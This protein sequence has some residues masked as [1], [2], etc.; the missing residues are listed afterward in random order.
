MIFEDIKHFKYQLSEQLIIKIYNRTI[1][2]GIICAG[3]KIKVGLQC[4]SLRLY[5]FSL[6]ASSEGELILRLP[7]STIKSNVAF[8]NYRETMSDKI[9]RL[10]DAERQYYQQGNRL[11][12]KSKGAN[13]YFNEYVFEKKDILRSIV[14][15]Y[16]PLLVII[17]IELN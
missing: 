5:G 15:P 7:H 8:G 10:M 9:P 2:K 14:L 3:K 4:K 13:I 11:A 1:K 17:M 6:G 16:N 12:F